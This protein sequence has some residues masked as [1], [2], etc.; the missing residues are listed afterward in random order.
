M[1]I[2]GGPGNDHQGQRVMPNMK[3][4]AVI[5]NGTIQYKLNVRTG[6]NASLF[7]SALSTSITYF[8]YVLHVIKI[9][10]FLIILIM[11]NINFNASIFGWKGL[12]A[13]WIP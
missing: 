3:W 8:V 13:I 4:P 7:P 10:I 5:K 6:W 2:Y 1:Y 12:V 11:Q 9:L